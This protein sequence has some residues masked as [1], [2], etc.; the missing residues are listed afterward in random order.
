MVN[1]KT[2]Y[3]QKPYFLATHCITITAVLLFARLAHAEFGPVAVPSTPD[4]IS[5]I[6]TDQSQAPGSIEGFTA[7]H[8]SGYLVQDEG[9]F[10]GIWQIGEPLLL[11]TAS[12]AFARSFVIP[13]GTVIQQT[14][15]EFR[16]PFTVSA[17][18]AYLFNMRLQVNQNVDDLHATIIGL[19][20]PRRQRQARPADR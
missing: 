18:G 10:D 3:M 7:V 12:I 11:R 2:V 1:S 13:N 8:Q 9:N 19:A 6:V 5:W 4:G 16:I 15:S 20:R 14:D 17:T